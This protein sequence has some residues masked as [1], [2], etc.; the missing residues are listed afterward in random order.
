MIEINFQKLLKCQELTRLGLKNEAKRK[1][2]P[3]KDIPSIRLSEYYRYK[4]VES[5]IASSYM[6]KPV[7]NVDRKR[8]GRP[9][10]TSIAFDR[11]KGPV[12]LGCWIHRLH[13]C[14]WV[15]FPPPQRVSCYN[16]K[17]SDGEAPVMLE[18]WGM[19]STP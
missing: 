4:K 9:R 5:I 12:D 14:R 13:L 18:L 11:V 8:S 1:F 7:Q 15:R 10:V 16:T 17:L 6:Q 19:R 3:Q 2:F